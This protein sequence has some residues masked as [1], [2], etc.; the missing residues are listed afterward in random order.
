MLS[1]AIVVKWDDTIAEVMC[2][3]PH[4]GKIHYHG[5]I[6]A[7]EGYPNSRLS[8]CD[9]LQQDYQLIWPFESDSVAQQL[10]LGFELDRDAGMWRTIGPD[11]EDLGMGDILAE[12]DLEVTQVRSS[13]DDPIDSLDSLE[14]EDQSYIEFIS[15]CVSN[16]IAEVVACL[17]SMDSPRKYLEKKC[18]SGNTALA[19]V[20]MEGHLDIVKLLLKRGSPI[21]SRNK[22]GET[23]LV[24]SL[25]HGTTEV[26]SHLAQHGASVAS[27]DT[28]G[29]NVLSHARAL[30]QRLEGARIYYISPPLYEKSTTV[31]MKTVADKNGEVVMTYLEDPNPSIGMRNRNYQ[32]KVDRIQLIISRCIAH[33][34]IQSRVKK[35]KRKRAHNCRPSKISISRSTV[36]TIITIFSDAYHVP[37][38]SE[39]KTFAY[40]ERGEEHGYVFAVSGWSG[41]KFADIDGCIDRELWTK[42]VF[43]F[44]KIIG[45]KLHT[46][47]YDESGREGSYHACHAEKQLMVYVLW[48]CTS[49]QTKPD[50]EASETEWSS[51]ERVRKLHYCIREGTHPVATCAQPCER[52]RGPQ[53]ETV[54]P[55][56]HITNDVCPDC[57]RFRE[58]TLS[59]TGIDISLRKL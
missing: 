8:H 26:A 7:M 52:Y 55:I 58:R 19:L 18:S 25:E 23:P 42:R 49:L 59:Y 45:H 12:L 37:M 1:L 28:Q 10:G 14:L 36:Q 22:K 38:A 32:E 57:S 2:P 17:D 29:T 11:I 43:E 4:C 41:G 40:L 3:F 51:Y 46:H 21:D 31:E 30:L 53:V 20:C 39:R 47:E 33:Y 48:H 24:I 54:K 56:I 44:S 16:D 27:S 35:Q 5:S 6:R 13:E 34:D 9:K 15:H 50:Q